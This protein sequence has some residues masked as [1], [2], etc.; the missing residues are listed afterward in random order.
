MDMKMYVGTFTKKNG[1]ERTMRFVRMQDL[2]EQ[3]LNTKIS[4]TG[5]DRKLA[6]GLELV[7]D[8]EHNGFRVFNWKTASEPLTSMDV[9]ESEY[10]NISLNNSTQ[11]G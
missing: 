8:V 5:T 4:G 10:L 1:D 7:W 9:E 3:F 2:P 6:E 11:V